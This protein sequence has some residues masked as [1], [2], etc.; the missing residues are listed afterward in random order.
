MTY[1]YLITAEGDEALEEQ[2]Q[3][4][5]ETVGLKNLEIRSQL[6]LDSFLVT[7]PDTPVPGLANACI[8]WLRCWG[9]GGGDYSTETCGKEGC[10]TDHPRE[11]AEA[12][13]NSIENYSKTP[14]EA[15]SLV[16]SIFDEAIGDAPGFDP[17]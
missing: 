3:K 17:I 1:E 2:L 16:M 12:I 5:M 7:L 11:L 9:N 14:Y 4:L 15:V 10:T 8:D 13:Y 6:T